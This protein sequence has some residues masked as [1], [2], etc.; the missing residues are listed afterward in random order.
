MEKKKNK[1]TLKL[2]SYIFNLINDGN[3][4]S[5][6][7]W[8]KDFDYKVKEIILIN[9]TTDE[10]ISKKITS[11]DEYYAKTGMVNINF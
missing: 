6:A 9:K 7:M 1:N 4:R 11:F 10:V 2:P 3:K 5:I 8:K